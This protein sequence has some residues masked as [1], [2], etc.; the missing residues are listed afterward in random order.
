MT[1][2]TEVKR[3]RGNKM[4]KR[5]VYSYMM[6][7]DGQFHIDGNIVCGETLKFNGSISGDIL[8][9]ENTKVIEIAGEV[10]GNIKTDGD[11]IVTES[12]IIRG[13]IECNNITLDEGAW[14]SGTIQ[15]HNNYSLS[16][17]RNEE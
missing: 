5:N 4:A 16:S 10:E 14:I 2:Y 7:G 3:K 6:M 17:E 12:A 8:G 13:N 15:T 1:L 11:V 9:G